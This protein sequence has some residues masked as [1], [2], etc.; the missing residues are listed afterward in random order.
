[1]W[2]ISDIMLKQLLERKGFKIIKIYYLSL[3]D[4]NIFKR[5]IEKIL[6]FIFRKKE[7]KHTLFVIAKLKG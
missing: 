6:Y 4:K 5:F 3:E 2:H 7:I 1:M